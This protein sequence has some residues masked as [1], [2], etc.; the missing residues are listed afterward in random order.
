MRAVFDLSIESFSPGQSVL[1]VNDEAFHLIKVARIKNDDVIQVFNGKGLIANAKV[2]EVS[3]TTVNVKIIDCKKILKNITVKLFLCCP[4]KEALEQSIVNA[5]EIGVD[6]II[7]VDS[8]YVQE[9]NLKEKDLERINRIIL[10]AHKQSNNP[11][12]L[13]FSSEQMISLKD[14]LAQGENLFIFCNQLN[15]F[16]KQQIKQKSISYLIG[17]EGGFS[18]SEIEMIEKSAA[19]TEK[20]STNIL[21]VPNAVTYGHAVLIR[22]STNFQ[23]E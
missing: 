22:E 2:I 12:L 11:F 10:N 8:D 6:E 23:T 20:F 7:L 1:I 18:T 21:R 13:K 14:V 3:R 15:K 4:K 17:P 19:N 9:R 16:K 5:V